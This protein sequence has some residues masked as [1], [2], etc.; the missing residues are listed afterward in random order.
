MT[1][2]VSPISPISPSKNVET[3]LG[4]YVLRLL[5]AACADVEDELDAG[6]RFSPYIHHSYMTICAA[7]KDR[8]KLDARFTVS[9]AAKQMFAFVFDRIIEECLAVTISA[10]D[11]VN[12]LQD[13]ILETTDDSFFKYATEF[14]AA[15][16]IGKTLTSACDPGCGLRGFVVGKMPAYVSKD[17]VLSLVFTTIDGF[18]KASAIA[19]IKL[20]WYQHKPIDGGMLAGLYYTCGLNPYMIADLNGCLREKPATKPRAKKPKDGVKEVGDANTDTNKANADETV[21]DAA[22]TG[23]ANT[24][25]G[26]VLADQPLADQPLADQPIIDLS[27]LDSVLNDI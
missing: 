11:D 14:T 10:D 22:K 16:P 20:W 17:R 23:G 4:E 1:E 15:Y 6:G 21:S 26:E 18:L 24:A 7:K 3:Y 12:T 19:L 2:T 9:D 5:Y 8:I 25:E 13:K 27:A